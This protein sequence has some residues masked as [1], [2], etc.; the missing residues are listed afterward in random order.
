MKE[1]L[2]MWSSRRERMLEEIVETIGRETGVPIRIDYKEQ[3]AKTKN[4][5]MR[6]APHEAYRMDGLRVDAVMG[7]PTLEVKMLLSR[8]K[9]SRILRDTEELCEYVREIEGECKK[10]E[11]LQLAHDTFV[12]MITKAAGHRRFF[13]DFMEWLESTDF[14]RAPASTKYHGSEEGGLVKHSLNV[15]KRLLDRKDLKC[16]WET[17]VIASLLHDVCKIDNYIPVEE[18]GN[19][20]EWKYNRNILLPIGHSERSIILIQQT[21]MTLTLEEIVAIRWH[22]GAF[23]N[24][25]RGGSREMSEA[26][27]KYTLALQLHL[28]DMEATYLDEGRN[29]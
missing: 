18:D 27:G 17:A 11:E 2:I 15:C 4:I 5:R 24:A 9:D 26:F 19:I 28:A 10:Q 12:E 25:V 16:S 14:F 1:I 8:V 6:Y 29:D 13:R 7:E 21:G 3:C 22:M 23:D 20:K